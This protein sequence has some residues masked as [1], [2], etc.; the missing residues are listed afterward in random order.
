M[1]RV[2]PPHFLDYLLLFLLPAR[3]RVMVSGDLHEE[4]LEV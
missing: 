3:N 4:F 1:K 2:A